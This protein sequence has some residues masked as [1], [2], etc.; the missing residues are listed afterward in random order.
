MAKA[1]SIFDLFPEGNNGSQEGA[2]RVTE[3]GTGINYVFMTPDDVDPSA[4]PLKA[5]TKVAFDSPGVE[6]ASNVQLA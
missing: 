5:G 2:G 4:L 1:G 6:Q 3:D